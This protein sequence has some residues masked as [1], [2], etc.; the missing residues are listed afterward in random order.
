MKKLKL[1]YLGLIVPAILLTSCGYGLSEVVFG[2]AYNSVNWNENY[3]RV[4]DQSI[5]VHDSEHNKIT[6]T[7]TTVLDKDNDYVFTSYNDPAFAIVEPNKDNFVYDSDVKGDKA[8]GKNNN[9]SSIDETFKYNV[10]SKLF[11]GRMFCGGGYEKVRVQVA[12]KNNPNEKS[13]LK[14]GFGRLFKKELKTADYFAMNFKCCVDFKTPSEVILEHKSEIDL[15]LTFYIK[16]SNG[17]T[18]HEV[19]YHLANVPTNT[20][21]GNRYNDFM[22]FGFKLHSQQ[23]DEKIDLARC[24]GMSIQYTFTDPVSTTKNLGHSMLVYECLFP[25]S[26]WC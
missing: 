25:H 11:D 4:W 13:G 24:A 3:Y 1:K 16:N 17:Y 8:Y 15:K 10:T 18:A 7:I 26:T 14:D 21:D 22:F 6:N 19:T 12:P 2:D 9:L 20:G 23:G 5:D